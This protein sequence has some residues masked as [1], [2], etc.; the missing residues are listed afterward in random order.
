M[1]SLPPVVVILP[2]RLDSHLYQLSFVCQPAVTPKM[3][4]RETKKS[5]FKL[6][7]CNS[8]T[9]LAVLL[10]CT[11]LVSTDKQNAS[12]DVL[13]FSFHL[14]EGSIRISI[15]LPSPFGWKPK[16]SRNPG[17]ILTIRNSFKSLSPPP[18]PTHLLQ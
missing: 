12:L 1:I 17:S 7:I 5:H 6:I 3:E 9:A 16:V 14:S 15:V 11:I 10:C 18:F 8:C 13:R 4:C 2:G